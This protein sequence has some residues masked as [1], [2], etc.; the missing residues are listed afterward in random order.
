MT[1]SGSTKLAIPEALQPRADSP[2]PQLSYETVTELTDSGWSRVGLLVPL[3]TRAG[4][5][6]VLKHNESDKVNAD[7]L[8]PLGETS[9]ASLPV[10]EQPIETLDRAIREELGVKEPKHLGLRI[11]REDGWFTHA[12]PRGVR[13]PGQFACAISPAVYVPPIAE[14]ALLSRAHGN[15]EICGL[16]P[17][18][19]GEILDRPEEQLRPGFSGWLQKLQ[20][21]DFLQWPDDT[22]TQRL[23]FSSVFRASL[24]DLDLQLGA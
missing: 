3:I 22:L 12:W 15:E 8:G 18:T 2:L 5:L 10:I 19:V 6:L 7:M 13:Y 1:N 9:K 20:E 17:M 4:K 21:T 16:E 23:D 11:R 14:T 24:V